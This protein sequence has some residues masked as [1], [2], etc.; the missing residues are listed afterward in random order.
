MKMRGLAAKVVMTTTTLLVEVEITFA[1]S[2][3]ENSRAI[4]TVDEKEN[5]RAINIQASPTTGF[6]KL[7]DTDSTRMTILKGPAGSQSHGQA[8]IAGIAKSENENQ[9]TGNENQA[10]NL[11]ENKNQTAL[12][13]SSQKKLSKER[14]GR[15]WA[16]ISERNQDADRRLAAMNHVQQENL[17]QGNVCPEENKSS[18]VHIDR[19]LNGEKWSDICND[20]KT[21]LRPG[22]N[23]LQRAKRLERTKRWAKRQQLPWFQ[24]AMLSISKCLQR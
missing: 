13:E 8:S 24:Q 10:N 18:M 5:S 20:E 11:S 14:A 15:L 21:K 6:A 17:A 9:P 12:S 3:V 1:D 16:A 22:E 19:K 4:N 7:E 23:Y 2:A